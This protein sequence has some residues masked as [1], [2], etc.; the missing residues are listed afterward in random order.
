MSQLNKN[1]LLQHLKEHARTQHSNMHPA[2]LLKLVETITVQE[3]LTVCMTLQK[4]PL[5]YVL[6]PAK[7]LDQDTHD[8]ARKLIASAIT[9]VRTIHPM[10]NNSTSIAMHLRG[11]LEELIR[12]LDIVGFR[13]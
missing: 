1:L 9:R 2:D 4:S 10:I 8:K 7:K 13:V 6:D 12:V 3:F 11:D 5:E